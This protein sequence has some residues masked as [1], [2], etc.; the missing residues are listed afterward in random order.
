MKKKILLVEDDQLV[1]NVYRNKLLLEG[2]EVEVAHDGEAGLGLLQSFRPDA[3][4]LDLMLP[5]LPGVEIIRKIRSEESSRQLPILVFSNTY[6]TSM[7][8]E[9]WK[10]GA[11]KC[12]AK[13]NCTPNQ[14]ISTLVGLLSGANGTPAPARAATAPATQ[15]QRQASQPGDDEFQRDLRRSLLESW[16][17]S[18]AAIRTLV[19][20][21]N[22]DAR[23]QAI[24]QLYR[25]IH[26][27]TGS[28]SIAG[29]AQIAQLTDALEALLKE[30][31]DKP[32]N[33]NVSTMR[34]VASAIDFLALSFEQNA[35]Q[36]KPMT[37]ARVLVV[38]DEA[39]SRRAI[40]YALEKAKLKSVSEENPERALELLAHT[41]FDLVFL[42]V[43]MPDMNGF[44]L[45]TRLRGLPAYKNTPVV[46]VTSLT[47]L[48]SR[49]NSTMSG[50]NDFIAKPFLFIEL[51][52]K[53]L[54]YVLR[55]QMRAPEK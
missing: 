38:D 37:N 16:P 44:E 48:E 30:L 5:K 43:D 53:A 11:N 20:A 41:R 13:A 6:L 45:C 12:L 31:G 49:A 21:E 40:I 7:V 29:F 27:L 8:Q 22:L 9:A 15:P 24:Q 18:L 1:A 36:P 35:Q 2:F 47:D 46:F 25:R 33:I 39:I 34:T 17:A 19:K 50:G 3:L 54:V 51:A 26:P 55:A 4:L 28:A 23:T 10:A 32:A 42:D 14:V 52:V